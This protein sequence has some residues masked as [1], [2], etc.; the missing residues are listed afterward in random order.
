[1]EDI[2]V[3]EL[4]GHWVVTRDGIIC[5]WRST[6]PAAINDAVRSAV[7]TARS[8]AH[9]RVLTDDGSAPQEVVWDS[10]PVGAPK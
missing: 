9:V 8:G 1:M 5:A 3:T 4:D 7:E 6:A 10:G 2:L